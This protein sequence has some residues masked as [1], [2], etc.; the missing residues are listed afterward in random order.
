[1][2]RVF[3]EDLHP[4][5]KLQH[6]GVAI[7]KTPNGR[8]LGVLYKREGSWRLLHL[9]WHFQL[10]DHPMPQLGSQFVWVNPEPVIDEIRLEVLAALCRLISERNVDRGLPY[11]FSKPHNW[12]DPATGAVREFENGMGLTCASFVLAVFSSNG[13][14]LINEDTWRVREDDKQFHN[15]VIKRMEATRVSP[16]HLEGMRKSLP[17]I[18]YRPEEVAGAAAC[19]VIPANFEPCCAKAV[20]ILGLLNHEDSC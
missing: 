13:T 2:D 7:Q 1:M 15:W 12:F 20:Q 17:A 10:G 14:P 6:A 19:E 5:T 18:R 8:H 16:E 3:T 11:G 9:G 4:E